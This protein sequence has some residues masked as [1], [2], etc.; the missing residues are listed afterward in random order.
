MISSISISNFQSH[1]STK[2]DLH[3][4]VNVIVGSSDVGKTAVIRALRW[5]VWNRPSGDTFRS[6]WGGDTK[7]VIELDKLVQ[8]ARSRGATNA[9]YLDNTQFSAIRTDVP[10]EVLAALNFDEINLQQ[11]FDRPFL[12]D[13][14]AGEVASHFNRVAHLDVIDRASRNVQSW[15][16]KLGQSI[17]ADK[18]RVAELQK[19]LSCFEGL[20]DLETRVEKLEKVTSKVNDL[21]NNRLHLEQLISHIIVTEQAIIQIGSLVKAGP[22]VNHVIELHAKKKIIGEKATALATVVSQTSNAERELVIAEEQVAKL[23]NE[24]SSSFP[25][26]CPLC[27]SKTR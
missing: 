2:L 9:Y 25:S 6:T 26:I 10:L 7:V 19:D 3:P 22:A 20:E 23:S 21:T 13:S 15:L 12:L 11:Q 17:D 18:Q 14:T 1:R 5:L 8:I 16:K 4:G 24:F 27:G